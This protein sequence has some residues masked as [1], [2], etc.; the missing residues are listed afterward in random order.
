MTG[1]QG[2][3]LPLAAIHLYG[4]LIAAAIA[5]GAWLCTLEERRLKLP[6]DLGVDI[7]LH[8]LPPA[9]IVSRL[10]YVA[11][12]WQ[13][14]SQDP[15]RILRIWEGGL[16]IYGAV[17]GGA[18]G[19]AL[20]AR[21]KKL[22]FLLLADIVAPALLLG[23]AIGRW[24]NYFNGEAFGYAV[25]NP[26]LQFFPFA[27]Q[28]GGSW[29]LATFFYESCWNLLGFL[30]LY[31]NRRRF[32]RDGRLGHVF[33][34][35]LLWY[36]FGRMFIEGLRTDSLMF[37]SL[38]VSQA[39]SLCFCVLALMKLLWDLRMPRWTLALP[40]LTLPMALW[41]P[42]WVGLSLGGLILLGL[43][44]LAYRRYPKAAAA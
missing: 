32:Q 25:T 31:L 38:R 35:Y 21:R 7:V 9:L 14:F 12:T 6:K 36:G 43:G 41:L 17:I 29:H 40:V 4:I 10:Y 20:L 44:V 28:V 5:I 13:E 33:F 34:W 15:L 42:G 1:V 30:F 37:Y 16:A 3:S 26:A 8:A 39:L 27:V 2:I 23:Q 22:P 24:G 11:F 19:V 18:L